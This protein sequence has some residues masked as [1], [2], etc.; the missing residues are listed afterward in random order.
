[1]T[2]MLDGRNSEVCMKID[3]I[4]QRREIEVFLPSNTAAVQTLYHLNY[5]PQPRQPCTC[6]LFLW[7]HK[8]NIQIHVC[9]VEL[10]DMWTYKY[11][12]GLWS[13]SMFTTHS[14]CYIHVTP[15]HSWTCWQTRF[16]GISNKF[17]MC[18]WCSHVSEL[19]CIHVATQLGM[20]SI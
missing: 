4:F 1:M 12:H 16:K 7:I 18:L 6:S 3:L 10:R 20:C 13:M 11:I 8:K 15:M 14:Y 9:T 17:K 2:A 19:H 5:L